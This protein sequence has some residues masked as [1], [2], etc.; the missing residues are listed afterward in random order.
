MISEVDLDCV[1][2]GSDE[3]GSSAC[4][5]GKFYCLHD[6]KWIPS[7]R[8]DDTICGNNFFQRRRY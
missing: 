2:D 3:P 5:K 6:Q 8:V 4:V 1:D 7:S